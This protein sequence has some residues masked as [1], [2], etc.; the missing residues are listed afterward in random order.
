MDL[1]RNRYSA[2]YVKALE[3]HIALL[4]SSLKRVKDTKDEV[5]RNGILNSLQLENLVTP[6]TQETN[7]TI[8]LETRPVLTR[9]TVKDDRQNLIKSPIT[10]STFSSPSPQN[11][12]N[13]NGNS[14]STTVG[15]NSIYPSNSLSI[16][17]K[18]VS[19]KQSISM[20]TLKN[21]SHSP[22]ILR[23]LSLFFKWLYPAHYMFIHRETFLS[24]FFGDE[25]TKSYYCSEELVFAIAALGSQA[26]NKNEELFG[27]SIQ[28]YNRAK[29][30]VMKK[31]FQLEDKSL[32]ESTSS[33][34]LAIIQTLLC[35]AF[36]DMGTGEN[37]MA[38]YLSGLAFRMAH[39]IGLH[40]NPEAWSHVYEDE[41]SRIDF[42]VRSRIYWGCYIADHLISVLFGRSTSLR[43]S[44]STVPETDELPDIETGIEDYLFNPGVPLSMA[45]PLKKLIVLS[46][47]TEVFAANIFIQAEN[48]DQRGEY[49][50]KFN[51]ELLN[52]RRDLSDDIKWDKESLKSMSSFNPTV[53]YVWFH[54]YIVLIS[55]NKP[56][57]FQF[58]DSR[59][60]IKEYIEEL[61]YLILL[62]KKNFN[63]YE[64]SNLYMVYS[65]ILAI[66]CLNT[67]SINKD[68]YSFF[69]EYLESETLN[70]DVAKK[71]I[72][73]NN[74]Y[75]NNVEAGIEFTDLL[76]TSSHG[77]DFALEYNFDF[78]L[79]NEI[80][81]L[82]NNTDPTSENSK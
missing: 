19:I 77:T 13:K 80:D 47:I 65:A 58:D 42:E 56:F 74:N 16:S 46:R 38:W 79:L 81:K 73:N 32:A 57:I 7:P 52:W 20:V 17:K 44:N 10:T 39:E 9:V 5:E 23:S 21:L 53:T 29:E 69:L 68:Y 34:K 1:R 27:Q 55:Y 72:E 25:S 45:N 48:I 66:Q 28:Y 67:D 30:I 61:Y 59:Q 41:L 35:L 64:K 43:V 3:S 54:Y 82:I 49:L 8:S 31:I 70:Y 18:K 33:S 22:L 75:N 71:F 51:V 4:E 62:W 2:A 14:T 6:N 24:A 36:Y 15:T 50:D 37:P 40:L 11:I 12:P 78:R 63:S 60:L 76:G 26:S